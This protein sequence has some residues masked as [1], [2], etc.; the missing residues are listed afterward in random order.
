MITYNNGYVCIPEGSISIDDEDEICHRMSLSQFSVLCE[1]LSYSQ[2][3]QINEELNS[4]ISRISQQITS[5][6]EAYDY[7][8]RRKAQSALSIVRQK[9]I[10]VSKR[11][12]YIRD[13]NLSS[14]L[15][16]VGITTISSKR[17][18]I[19]RCLLSIIDNHLNLS[20]LSP[21]S[22]QLIDTARSVSGNELKSVSGFKFDPVRGSIVSPDESD[23]AVMSST[24]ILAEEQGFLLSRSWDMVSVLEKLIKISPGELFALKDEAKEILS[25][26]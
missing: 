25:E 14:I 18:S 23:I 15:K 24:G 1:S 11:I 3:Q 7:D 16:S 13:N 5:R 6:N 2:A 4:R 17:L 12:N 21:E 26:I 9:K 20:S 10:I 22:R 19:I 8:W